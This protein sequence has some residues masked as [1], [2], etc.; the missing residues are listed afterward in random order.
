[1]Q[2]FKERCEDLFFPRVLGFYRN[3]V[4]LA[5]DKADITDKERRISARLSV[6][7]D[8]ETRPDEQVK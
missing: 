5:K 6:R 1:M 8:E 3:R 4:G 7:Q 2:A